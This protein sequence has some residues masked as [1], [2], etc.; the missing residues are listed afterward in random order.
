MSGQDPP[1]VKMVNIKPHDKSLKF[2]GLEVKQFL[3]DYKLAA[4]LDGASDYNKA[5]KIGAFVDSGETQTILGT[6]DGY[7]PPDWPKLKASMLSYWVDVDKALFTKT[8]V[9]SLAYLVLKGHIELSEELKKPFY[10]TFSEGFQSRIREQL[11]KDGTLIVTSDNCT[12]LLEFKVLRSAVD[13]VMKGQI[14]LTFEDTRLLAPVPSQFQEANE[15]MKK[16]GNNQRPKALDP[17]LQAEPSVEELTRMFKAFKQYMKKE[18]GKGA[19]L[20]ERP[21]LVFYYCHCENHGMAHCQELVKDKEAGLVE[22]RG[23]NFFLPNSALI[24]F[25]CRRP[26]RHVVASFQPSPSSGQPRAQTPTRQ[27]LTLATTKYKTSCGALQPWYPPAISSQSFASAYKAEPA[28]RKQHKESK[29]YKAPL[30]LAIRAVL[31]Q[32][33]L[34]GGWTGTVRPK[35]EP[36]G[37]TDL[38]D[39]S[40][41]VLCDRSQE[42]IG[43]ACPTR[44]QVLWSDSAC[45]TTGRT[46]LFKH[47]LNCRVRPVNAGSEDET[48]LFDRIMN[49]PEP[50]QLPSKEP[51]SRPVTPPKPSTAPKARFERGVSRDHPDSVDGVLRKISNLPVSMMVAE[52]CLISPA[53]ADGMK[54]WVALGAWRWDPKN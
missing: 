54:K 9:A 40:R 12:R 6:L 28:G 31:E 29:P 5:R 27:A 19:T 46:R 21:P 26:I 18:G 30:V 13:A 8:D 34:T 22:Q 43:Q 49:N 47:R 38:S 48:E 14:A 7:K 44:R 25:D 39:R 52:I 11:I 53:V 15:V 24:P 42:L 50:L 51:C 45:L 33:C 16:M 36:T 37:R 10:Q 23:L 17:S 4:E 1:G 41:L 3:G 2:S 35:Q 20:M 32:P